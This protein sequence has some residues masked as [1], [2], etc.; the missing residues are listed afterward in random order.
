LQF[1]YI[2]SAD[3]YRASFVSTHEDQ[4]LVMLAFKTLDMV[5]VNDMA[6]VNSKK[7]LRIQYFF[8]TAERMTAKM[9]FVVLALNRRVMTIRANADDIR[10]V[11]EIGFLVSE[12]RQFINMKAW[13]G[14]L[15]SI[16]QLE[17]S[18]RAVVSCLFAFYRAQF[19]TRH[20][21]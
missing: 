3:W 1:P 19:T 5:Q 16:G 8:D 9:I 18:I 2:G 21:G 11:D 6:A 13:L 15:S 17:V 14:W 10:Y 7:N 4:T 20:Q 12:N